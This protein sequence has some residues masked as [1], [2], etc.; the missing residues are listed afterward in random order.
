MR[1][2][3]TENWRGCIGCGFTSTLGPVRESRSKEMNREV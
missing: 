1:V 2:N 3:W